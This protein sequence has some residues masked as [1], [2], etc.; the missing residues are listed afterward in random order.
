MANSY[1]TNIYTGKVITE[2]VIFHD[3]YMS[4]YEK[5]KES[6]SL[7]SLII[8]YCEYNSSFGL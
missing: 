2:N 8:Y 4:K 7:F 5:L 3:L 1:L 6:M